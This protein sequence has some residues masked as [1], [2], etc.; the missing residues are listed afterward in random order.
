MYKCN[1][2]TGK[3]ANKTL[4]KKKKENISPELKLD[5]DFKK[6]R[7]WWAKCG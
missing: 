7:R 4:E 6:I 5:L 1:K 3:R 2:I